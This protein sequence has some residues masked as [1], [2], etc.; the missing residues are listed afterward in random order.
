[1][2]DPIETE[3]LRGLPAQPSHGDDVFALYGGTAVADA[4]W[5]GALG[6]PR[7]REQ[8]AE[9]LAS[10]ERHW[11]EHGFGPWVWSTHS[12][13]VIARGGLLITNVQGQREIELLYA[14]RPEFWGRGYATELALASS[15]YAFSTLDATSIVAFTLP[16][17]QA[18]RRVM[19]RAQF[20]YERDITHAGMPHVLYR[21]TAA[22]PSAGPDLSVSTSALRHIASV[23]S[24]QRSANIARINNALTRARVQA[25]AETVVDAARNSGRVTVN[26]HPDR[27]LTDGRTVAQALRDDAMYRNQFETGISSGGLT[28]HAG[29][30]RDSWEQA[31]FAGTYQRPGVDA[32]ER[33]KYGGLNLMNNV[34]GACPRF[35]SCHLRL[36]SRVGARTTFIFGDSNTNPVD[37]GLRDAFEPVLA[38]LLES[39]AL[40]NGVLGADAPTF[41]AGLLRGDPQRGAGVFAPAMSHALDLYIEAQIHGEIRLATDVD[42]VVIDTAFE[43]TTTGDELVEAAQRHGFGVEWYDGFVLPLSDIP[44]DTPA[45]SGTELTRWQS[46]CT[47]GRAVRLAQRVV[48]ESPQDACLTSANIGKAARNI[49]ETPGRWRDWGDQ[50]QVLVHLKDLWLI[51]VANGQA[52]QSPNKSK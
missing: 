44:P 31:M 19:E 5:P 2:R 22:Q 39:V 27:L 6:G 14:V 21:R 45:A 28:A 13:E 4:L 47:G 49:V 46:F 25:E 23:T 18:S 40:G 50:Q 9:T 41:V 32:A 30:E 10:D 52:S 3:R 11:D 36:A 48:A 35:G 12:G 7:T 1:M 24:H 38:A 17:N 29:G 43:G 16:D 20:T 33:P 51:L 26:F 37:I 8:V 42:A 15:R 34:N